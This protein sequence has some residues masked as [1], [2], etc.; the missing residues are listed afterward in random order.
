[1]VQ[2]SFSDFRNE[3]ALRLSSCLLF[4]SARSYLRYIVYMTFY[5]YIVG[6]VPMQRGCSQ[7]EIEQKRQAALAKRKKSKLRVSPIA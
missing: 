2:S 3:V 5:M 7:Q 1:M 6:G 4:L